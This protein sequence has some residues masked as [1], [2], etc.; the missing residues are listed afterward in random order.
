MLINMKISVITVAYKNSKVVIDLLN[1]IVKYN[2]IGDE[3]RFN[4]GGIYES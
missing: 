1:F 4:I 3:L 2:Y